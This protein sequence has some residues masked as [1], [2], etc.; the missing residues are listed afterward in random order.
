MLLE[1]QKRLKMKL[2]DW[3]L[4][5]GVM[6]K[7]SDLGNVTSISKPKIEEGYFFCFPANEIL[8]E[9]EQ[10]LPKAHFACG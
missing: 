10:H 6:Y 4:S 1:T 9:H 5:A 2:A 3:L 7:I 8:E